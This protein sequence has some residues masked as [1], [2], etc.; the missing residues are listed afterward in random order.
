MPTSISVPERV[1]QMGFDAHQAG[2]PRIENP[3]IDPDPPIA[4]PADVQA[5]T[6]LADAWFRGWDRARLNQ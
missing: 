4:G 3:Y 6:V 5:A 2:V 1:E